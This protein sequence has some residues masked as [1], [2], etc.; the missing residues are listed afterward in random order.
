MSKIDAPQPN[1][2]GAAQLEKLFPT[3]SFF[4]DVS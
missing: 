2:F 4:Y 1:V 3:S